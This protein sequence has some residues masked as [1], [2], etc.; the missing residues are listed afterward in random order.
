M[1]FTY[2]LTT[3]I[4]KARLLVPDGSLEISEVITFGA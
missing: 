2:D 4:G 1:A 3:A